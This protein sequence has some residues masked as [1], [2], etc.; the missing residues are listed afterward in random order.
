MSERFPRDAPLRR[1]LASLEVL[2]FR[3]VREGNHVA[4]LPTMSS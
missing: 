2:G 1:V 4:M 3:V